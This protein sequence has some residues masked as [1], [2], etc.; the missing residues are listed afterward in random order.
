MWPFSKKSS[1]LPPE[2]EE[3]FAR[4]HRFLRDDREQISQYPD[5]LRYRILNGLNVD[6]LPGATGSFG[7]TIT[8]PVP[9]NG[10]IGQILYLSSLRLGEQ[11]ILFHRLRSFDTIDAYECVSQD[12]RRWDIIFMDMYHP[13]KSTLAPA[14]YS[15]V[16]NALLSGINSSLSNFPNQLYDTIASFSNKRFGMSLADPAIRFSLEQESFRPPIY[17]TERISRILRD[18]LGVSRQDFI[19]RLTNETVGGQTKLYDQ[20]TKFAAIG[21]K[22]DDIRIAELMYFSLSLTAYSIFRWS[23]KHPNVEVSDKIALNVLRMNIESVDNGAKLSELVK[24]YQERHQSYK[25]ALM[26]MSDSGSWERELALL[27]SKNI[28]GKENPLVGSMLS[29]SVPIVLAAIRETIEE[30]ELG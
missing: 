2:V 5:Q 23:Q 27:L 24:Q 8:N 26:L 13:R 19:E 28:L 9:V 18:Q 12:G 15:I 21:L 25:N 6:K 4:L 20:L 3:L 29:A 11:R 14:D 16:E 10:P 30:L 7:T 1:S 22:K 17:H